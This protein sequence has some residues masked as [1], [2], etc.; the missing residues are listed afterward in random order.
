MGKFLANQNYKNHWYYSRCN[1][2]ANIPFVNTSGNSGNIY[3]NDANMKTK[4]LRI[5]STSAASSV[6][7]YVDIWKPSTQT[8]DNFSVSNFTEN[9]CGVI[10]SGCSTT[11]QW[12]HVSSNKSLQCT[13]VVN[14]TSDIT[15]NSFALYEQV[16]TSSWTTG[17]IGQY[18]LDN[19]INLSNGES[20]TVVISFVA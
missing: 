6:G 9:A 14:A 19:P 17:I 13:V 7:N 10:T 1:G 20:A 11:S 12:A 4:P 3:Q 2:P 8:E 18:Y 16:Y 5:D 15:I